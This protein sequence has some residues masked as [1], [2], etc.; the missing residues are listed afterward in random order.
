[1][2]VIRHKRLEKAQKPQPPADAPA[3]TPSDAPIEAKRE[4]LY[5]AIENAQAFLHKREP[6]DG[7]MAEIR[8]L[9]PAPLYFIES[10]RQ[11]MTRTGLSPLDAFYYALIPS[12]TR[13][14]LSQQWGPNPRLDTLSRMTAFLRTLYVGVHEERFYLIMLNRQGVLI[15]AAMLQKGEVD[16]APF[17]LGQLLSTA[18]TEDARYI[19]L[20]H[21]HP[22]GTTQ[23]SR[24]DIVCTLRALNAVAPLKLPLLDHIIVVRN[25]AVSIRESGLI[26]ALLWSA[27]SQNSKIVREWLDAPLLTE[28]G[29]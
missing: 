5:R 10:N 15:R 4:A 27:P 26:P 21:N 24:E 20:A 19:V 1:M 17:Y 11:A 7:V 25:G 28:G 18:L 29:L 2:K 6:Q 22:G 23:P 8:R 12:L 9:Y 14:S 16:S 13:T 3:L